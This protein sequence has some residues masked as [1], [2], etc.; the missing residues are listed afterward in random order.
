MQSVPSF[1]QGISTTDPAHNVTHNFSKMMVMYRLLSGR[2][3][4]QIS[5]AQ[6]EDGRTAFDVTSKTQKDA[7]SIND[8]VNGTQYSVYGTTYE[9]SS[10]QNKKV[11]RINIKKGDS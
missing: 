2:S 10:K 6:E 8:M 5:T 4:I 9:V 11:V 3:D 1:I 7:A